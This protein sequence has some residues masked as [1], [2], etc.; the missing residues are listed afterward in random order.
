MSRPS[1]TRDYGQLMQNA[2]LELSALQAKLNTLEHAATEPIAIIGIGCR[3]PGGVNSP[4]QLWLLC[5]NGGDAIAEVP[6]DRWD[7]DAYYD[8][9]LSSYD[10][11]N[12]RW[13]GFLANI[14][15]FDPGFFGISTSEAATIDPQQRLLLEV[16]W[17]ALENAG[18]DPLQLAGSQ[19][20]VFVG[21]ATCDYYKAMTAIPTR[22][23]TGIANS[24]AA[25]RL[26]YFL[27]A[28]G[29]S[30]TID[31]ACSS[32]LVAI[33]TACQSL[34]HQESNL[35]LVGGVNIM[36][37]PEVNITFSQA[38]MM[39]S[40]GRCKSFDATADGYVRGE[41]CGVVILK[42]LSDAVKDG[43]RILALLRGTAVNHNGRSVGLTAPN[44]LA[45]QAVIRQALA[46]ARVAPDEIDYVEAHGTGTP[47][48]DA[49]ELQAIFGVLGQGRNLEQ[50]CGLGSVKTNIGNLEA[51]GGIAAFIKTVL[52]L[53]HGEIP[54]HPHFKTINP[55][56]DIKPTP[57]LIP[58]IDR[59]IDI[60]P[61][62]AGVNSFGFGGTNAHVVL[63]AASDFRLPIL[64]FRLDDADDNPKLL[65][66]LSAKTETALRELA[67]CY[68][69]SL[70]NYAAQS[71]PDICFTTNIGRSHFNHRH[72]IIS[73]GDLPD[74]ISEL[75]TFATSKQTTGRLESDNRP[76]IAFLFAGQGSQYVGMGWEL[77]NSQPIFR[78][79]LDDCDRILR[80][81][82]DR[83]LLE[84][85]YPLGEGEKGKGEG[86]RNLGPHLLD[87]TAY[88]QPALFAVEYALVKLWQSWGIEP[89]AVMGHSVGEYVAACVTGVFSLEEGLYLS[90]EPG[91]LMATQARE[92]QM[93]AV[94]AAKEIVEEAI[95][96]YQDAVAIAAFNGPTQT[97]IAG[98]RQAVSAAIA[99]LESDFIMTRELNVAH[100]FHSPLVD[101]IQ[102]AFEQTLRQMQFHPPSLPFISHLSG[103][104][105]AGVLDANYWRSQL[106]SP[107]RFD[108]GIQTL[109]ETG[110]NIFLEIGPTDTLA[111][112]GK[113][114]LPKNTANWLSS[115]R[116]GHN[117]WRSLLD[118]LATLYEKGI[119]INW[120]EFHRD[121]PRQRVALPTYPFQRQRCWIDNE[122]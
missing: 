116:Q 85:L 13:G 48:G 104:F 98:D 115:L 108:R 106:R 29:P 42:R 14:D 118:T 69:D 86:E 121:S 88:A 75:R 91:R 65:L 102:N 110:Y 36:L 41:G 4:E 33:H 26:S 58:T 39:S 15:L 90:A 67:S 92:G 52:C 109:A 27:D 32:S 51:A 5:K 45:Q 111:S 35:A 94:F 21:I 8:P 119:N 80:S 12:T 95:A 107:V 122:F 101:P 53:Q 22:A 38:G 71:I 54:P 62:F 82:L 30:V 31:T 83:P 68:A 99:R 9:D 60:K 72:A 103:E 46:N 7:V 79:A 17:E 97:V 100:A 117:D 105:E 89:D 6:S 77:Y 23:G 19:T 55:H 37:L 81:Y 93:V 66:T 120:S 74:L 40:D 96:S 84:V 78:A 34:R 49:I 16:S 47:M 10:K 11:T 50:P 64:D 87:E 20:G 1:E 25:N 2:L 76:K 44:G 57:F 63:E 112:M 70:E 73:S 24:M 18:Y 61:R 28:R 113:R 56:I 59:P 43:D 114:C 3:F